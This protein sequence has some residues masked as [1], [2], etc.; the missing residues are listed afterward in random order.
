MEAGEN[1]FNTNLF[2][3]DNSDSQLK[4]TESS[5]YARPCHTHGAPVFF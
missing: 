5:D 2:G 4:V 3:K 1:E